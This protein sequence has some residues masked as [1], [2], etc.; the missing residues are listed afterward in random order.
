MKVLYIHGFN[1]GKGQ[2][3]IDL[4]KSGY[5]VYCPQLTNNV[6]EDIQKLVDLV[7]EL[8]DEDLHIVGCSLGGFYALVLINLVCSD[9]N[10]IFHIINPS[11]KPSIS[12]KK[13][14]GKTI[15]NYKTNVEFTVTQSFL[16]DLKEVGKHIHLIEKH[17][18]EQVLFYFGSEDAVLD[19]SKTID[20]IKHCKIPSEV[21]KSNQGHRFQDISPIIREINKFE[22]FKEMKS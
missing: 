2:K 13:E 20:W 9:R 17:E 6:K 15:R 16:D 19:H 10:V 12:L 7:N 5:K 1:S 8:K 18:F 14:L 22:S 21:I 4:E 3:V 11:M